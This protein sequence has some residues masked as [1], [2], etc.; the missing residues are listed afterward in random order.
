MTQASRGYVQRFGQTHTTAVFLVCLLR[1]NARDMTR[2]ESSA[3]GDPPVVAPTAV[4]ASARNK[5]TDPIETKVFVGERFHGTNAARASCE[6]GDGL[7][8]RI[9][10]HGNTF[11]VFKKTGSSCVI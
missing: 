5:P 2:H 3:T 9:H 6:I 11:L 4:K 7:H 10:W 1:K 8:D